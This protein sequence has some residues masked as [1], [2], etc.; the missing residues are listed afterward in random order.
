MSAEGRARF[1]APARIKVDE[2]IAVYDGILD[3]VDRLLKE[4]GLTTELPEPVMPEGIEDFMVM[5][6]NGDP[7]QPNDLT[8]LEGQEL[9]KIFSYFSNWSNYVQGILTNAQC[10]R[11]VIKSK[12]GMLEKALVITY[13][14]QDSGMSDAKAKARVRLDIRFVDSE[15]AYQRAVAYAMQINTRFDQFKRSEKVISR[16]QTRR[17]QE[18]EALN[19]EQFGGKGR[20]SGRPAF[21]RG[22]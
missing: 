13:Q 15:A 19:H 21:T 6:A 2:L 17:Q 14:E 20:S 8:I 22:R 16:E 5:A 11:D 12:L 1:S 4:K 7:V 10:A 9:G 18:L 3:E